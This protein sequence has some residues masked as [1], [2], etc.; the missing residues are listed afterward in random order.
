MSFNYKFTLSY[1]GS[2]FKG[3]QR[4]SSEISAQR[5]F[6]DA[7]YQVTGEKVK[8]VGAG[9]T[10]SGVHALGQVAHVIFKKKYVYDR[11]K[12]GT[13]FY[14]KGLPLTIHHVEEMSEDFHARFSAIRRHYC[15]RLHINP[16]CCPLR[17]GHVWWIVRP[18]NIKAMKKAATF[19]KGHHDFSAFRDAECGGR[20]PLK[21]LDRC[22][23]IAPDNPF[24][25]EEWHIH[26]SARSF[27]HRQVRIMVGSLVEVG[28]NRQP[29]EWIQ[30][31]LKGKK[32]RCYSGPTAP[33]E[34]LYFMK[35]TYLNERDNP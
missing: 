9:R 5:A 11:L 21:T 16:T 25:K 35:V 15:Y 6:E 27:L 4:Q 2:P 10:D 22:E 12:R 1:N 24:M 8:A 26:V 31:L 34:G 33:P 18:L 30:R 20:S 13:N 29:P 28:L 23:L 7:L 17:V 19:F 3:W 14:L 32:P